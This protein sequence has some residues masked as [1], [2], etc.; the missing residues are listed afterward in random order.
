[1]P[2][3]I[4]TTS[5]CVAFCY[6]KVTSEEPIYIN[7]Q[8][9]PPNTWYPLYGD[10]RAA[11]WSPSPGQ[12]EGRPISILQTSWKGSKLN[13][14]ALRSK[15]TVS[16]A[17][18]TAYTSLSSTFPFIL[19]VHLALERRRILAKRNINARL[20][21]SQDDQDE[22]VLL[23][24]ERGPRVMVLGPANSGKSTMI[25]GLLNL[26][27]GSGMGWSPGVIGLDPGTVSIPMPLYTTVLDADFLLPF[28]VVEPL[29]TRIGVIILANSSCTDASPFPPSG[30]PAHDGSGHD[31]RLRCS[32]ARLVRR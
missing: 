21:Y 8:E 17:P 26:A 5:S 15:T 23:E 32:H 19:S 29:G 27:V 22:K 12:I 14:C 7:Y 3:S 1:L 20:D 10:L 13:F 30:I 2:Y 16:S 31:P 6:L 24:Q 4:L 11:I 28:S 18:S 9:I 25:K